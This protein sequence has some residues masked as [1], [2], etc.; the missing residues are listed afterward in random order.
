MISVGSIKVN[1]ENQCRVFL[2]AG[3]W[4]SPKTVEAM[5]GCVKHIHCPGA[6]KGI[7]FC[8]FGPL[9]ERQES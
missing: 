5:G 8:R 6:L 4:I 7:G 1:V 3:K 9:L 2:D